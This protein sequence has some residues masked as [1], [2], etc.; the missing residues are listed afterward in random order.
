MSTVLSVALLATSPFLAGQ[1]SADAPA[2]AAPDPPVVVSEAFEPA[3]SGASAL[4]YNHRLVPVGARATVVSVASQ[5][6]TATLLAINGLV[7][8]RHYGAHVHMNRCG[9]APDDSGSHTQWH[10]D[11]VQPSVNP[12]YANP[13]NEIWLDFT[14]DRL[15]SAVAASEVTWP[16]NQK[17]A[18]SV[19]IHEH[20]TS[21]AP[22]HAGEA[23][24]RVACIDVDFARTGGQIL[25]HPMQ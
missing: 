5:R 7:P 6:G 22:G 3:N 12:K 17:M 2:S 1:A 25:G 15:G 8:D 18:R 19:V 24:P 4:T 10:P 11:P 23:G 9:P 21:T 14:T 20:G 13:H 16:V